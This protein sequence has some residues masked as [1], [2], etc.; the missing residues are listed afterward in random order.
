MVDQ[1]SDGGINMPEVTSSPSD[2]AMHKILQ[3]WHWSRGIRQGRVPPVP[4][5]PQPLPLPCSCALQGSPLST[6]ASCYH[7]LPGIG[8][9]Q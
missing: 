3:S 6:P 5:L 4:L 7:T 9:L 1:V 2:G 8:A